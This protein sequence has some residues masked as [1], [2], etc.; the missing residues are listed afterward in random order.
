M[1]L[2]TALGIMHD[3]ALKCGDPLSE[4]A[5]MVVRGGIESRQKALEQILAL[6]GRSDS[7]EFFISSEAE[8]ILRSASEL[9]DVPWPHTNTNN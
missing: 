7:G 5:G 8:E 3:T 1:N 4:Q 9:A 6:I 2:R